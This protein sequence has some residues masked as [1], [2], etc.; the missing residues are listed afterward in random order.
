M[1]RTS[2][3]TKIFR[4]EEVETTALNKVNLNVS[5]GE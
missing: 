3:L 5:E 1:I 2:E 4:T